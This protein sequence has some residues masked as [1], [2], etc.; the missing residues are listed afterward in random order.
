M[1]AYC[2]IGKHLLNELEF[3]KIASSDEMVLVEHI[4]GR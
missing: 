2:V 3:A 1:I 4:C